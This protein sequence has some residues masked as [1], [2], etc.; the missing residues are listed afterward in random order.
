M[1]AWLAPTLYPPPSPSLVMT[2][3]RCLVEPGEERRGGA[4][5]CERESGGEPV[6]RARTERSRVGAASPRSL[7]P[8][9]D[10]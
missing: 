8:T 5:A 10:P 9:S 2:P 7:S 4:G 6:T 1:F 3:G